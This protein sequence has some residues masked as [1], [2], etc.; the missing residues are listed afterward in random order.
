MFSEAWDAFKRAI[1]PKSHAEAMVDE[2]YGPEARGVADTFNASP[3]YTDWSMF[4]DIVVK[5]TGRVIEIV[6]GVT[7]Q[8]TNATEKYGT[9]IKDYAQTLAIW[10][11]AAAVVLVLLYAFAKK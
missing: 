1:V 11:F 3:Y 8:V 9:A 5:P 7:E 2:I 10:L 6:G 4:P